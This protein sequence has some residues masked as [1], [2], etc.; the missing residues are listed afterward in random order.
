MN[1]Q[2]EFELRYKIKQGLDLVS[3]RLISRV[4]NEG[5]E[6]VCADN[7]GQIFRVKASNLSQVVTVRIP[8]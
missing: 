5:V 1:E 3:Q 8:Q 2:E 4:K 7:K 6:L